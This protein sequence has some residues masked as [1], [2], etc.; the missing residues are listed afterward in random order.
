V[1]IVTPGTITEDSL[2][3]SRR[4]NYL[5]A[6]ADAAGGLGL[7][8][9]DVS[10]GAFTCQP[11][12]ERNLTHALARL[13]P[14]ELLAPDRL[15]QRESLY[16]VFGEYRDRLSPLPSAR[17][18]STNA[19]KRLQA[20]YGVQALDA[21]GGFS[22][23]EIAA[24]GTLV[25]YV[26]LTQKGKL[27]RIGALKRMGEGAAMEIDA[28]TRRNLELAETLSGERKGSLLQVIDRTVTGAGARLLGAHLA[29]PLTDPAE[30]DARLDAV[31]FFVEAATARGEVRDRLKQCP[32]VE[33]A[34]SRLSL[35][36]GGPRDL[37]NIRDTLGQVP[38]LRVTITESGLAT[39]PKAL[40]AV[41]ERLGRH[42]VLVDRLA[43]ALDTDLPMLARDGGF[44]APGYHPQLDELRTLRDESKRLIAGLQATYVQQT[45]ISSLKVKH[46]NVL[47]YFLEVPAKQGDK[48]LADKEGPFLH[49]GTVGAGR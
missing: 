33:R 9:L 42:D 35:G 32:D 36:R 38:G 28:A 3:D 1:R 41:C 34:L 16:D 27:P 7:A 47:G 10:T 37:A 48:L 25:D 15:I 21:F 5:A 22:R 23:A 30:I 26:E 17:F 40:K 45:G 43:R 6:V 46:N 14:G 31:Q 18:D 24:A 4:H 20:L 29:A 49:R 19:G 12:E 13:A 11:V 2:L 39:V 8:W 44:I